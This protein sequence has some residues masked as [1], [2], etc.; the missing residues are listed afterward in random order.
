MKTADTHT[1][2]G[3]CCFFLMCLG[4]VGFQEK[5]IDLLQ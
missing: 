3:V 4:A 2:V 1:V 5:R